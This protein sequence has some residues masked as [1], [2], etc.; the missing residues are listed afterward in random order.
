MMIQQLQRMVVAA[1]TLANIEAETA[2][3]A[4]MM[5]GVDVDTDALYYSLDGETWFAV[6]AGSVTADAPISI[7]SGN[8]TH[9]SSGVTPGTYTNPTVTINATGHVTAASNGTVA[10]AAD[11]IHGLARWIAD[12]SLTAFELP[13]FAEYIE[14]VSDDGAVVDSAIFSLSADRTQLVFD[15]A[16]IAANIVQANYVI[17]RIA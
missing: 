15:S 16:P 13:D 12:G 2:D 14:F 4:E 1:D 10:S 7:T 17:A 3:L 6:G 5:F 8:I 11:H 9:D